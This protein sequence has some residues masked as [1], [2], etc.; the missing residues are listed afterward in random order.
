[1]EHD[2]LEAVR[3]V[4]AARKCTIKRLVSD[5]IDAEILPEARAAVRGAAGKA[6]SKTARRS[7]PA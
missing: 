2:Q 7:V 5:W 4:A 1:L 6:T 3:A